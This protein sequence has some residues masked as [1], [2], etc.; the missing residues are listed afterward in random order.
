MSGAL[1]F[2]AYIGAIVAANV[3]ITTIGLV[4]VGF[5]LLAPAGVFFAGLAFYVRDELQRSQGRLLTVVAILFGAALSAFL[6]PSLALA[7]GVAFLVSELADQA[8]YTPLQRR[9]LI[10]AVVASNCVG[11]VIDSVLFLWLAGFGMEL[12]LGLT[13]GKLW[14]LVPVVAW[15]RLVRERRRALSVAITG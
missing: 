10:L 11:L 7:S 1:W 2:L 6:S 14:T 5:G 4:P 8:V 13:V 3:S 9:G 12:L 15:L